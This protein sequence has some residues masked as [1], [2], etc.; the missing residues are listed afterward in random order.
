MRSWWSVRAGSCHAGR[1]GHWDRFA[2]SIGTVLAV[3]F[4]DNGSKI[5]GVPEGPDQLRQYTASAIFADELGT[6]ESPRACFTA[7]KPCIDGGG[8]LT[9]LSSAYPGFL[10]PPSRGRRWADAGLGD[11]GSG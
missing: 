4:L 5:I 7:M 8:R 9:I 6:C 1:R 2:S 11:D 10:R 3:R